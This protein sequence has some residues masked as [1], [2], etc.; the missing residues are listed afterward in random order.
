M[1]VLDPFE[2]YEIEVWPLPQFEN[3]DKTQTTHAKAHLNSLEY[4]IHNEALNNS[5]FKAILNEKEPPPATIDVEIPT[6]FRQCIIS[7][8]V[9]KIRAHPDFR[10]LGDH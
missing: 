10:M 2:V 5:K 1:S 7:P 6:S 3:L 4:K 9:E 8:E